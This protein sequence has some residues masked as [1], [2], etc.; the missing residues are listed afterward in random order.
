[1][2]TI[3]KFILN[4]KRFPRGAAKEQMIW[5]LVLIGIILLI[6]LVYQFVAEPGV[7]PIPY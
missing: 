4:P 7:P 3:S 5:T 2:K 6:V 1:M